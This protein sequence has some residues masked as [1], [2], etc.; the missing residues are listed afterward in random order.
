MSLTEA[1]LWQKLAAQVTLPDMLTRIE[2]GETVVGVSDVEYV[3]GKWHG[4][5]ELKVAH[6]LR[7]TSLLDLQHPF[8]LGQYAWLAHHHR[9]AYFLFSWLVIGRIAKKEI[10]MIPA[11]LSI[12]LVQR[13]CQ[14]QD[15]RRFCEPVSCNTPAD[16]IA[17]LRQGAR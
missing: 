3:A 14:L 7:E 8:S 4:W 12:H 15:V 9:P 5:I 10:L 1:K 6:G 16:V 11:P 13:K 17:V 2:T